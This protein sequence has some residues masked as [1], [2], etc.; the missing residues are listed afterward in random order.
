MFFV[1]TLGVLQV[2]PWFRDRLGYAYEPAKHGAV[3]D[4]LIDL[5]SHSGNKDAGSTAQHHMSL[6][7]TSLL[8]IRL[9]LSLR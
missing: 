2:L 5:V 4:W 1:K 6:K 8:Q 9:W 3:S 7:V